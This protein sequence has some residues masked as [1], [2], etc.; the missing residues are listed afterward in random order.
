MAPRWLRTGAE[1]YRRMIEALGAA[2]QSVRFETYLFRS[3]DVGNRFRVALEEAARR[4]VR[5]QVLLDGF[6]SG[7]IPADYWHGLKQAGGEVRIFNPLQWSSF[8]FRDHRKLMLVDDA[9]A[10]VGGFNIAAEYDGDG[11]ERGWRDLGMELSLPKAVHAL[12]KSFDEMFEAFDLRHRLLRRIRHP[13]RR[14]IP[15]GG[16]G[17]VLLSGPRLAGN[18]FRKNLLQSL[19]RA[20]NVRIISGYFLPDFRLRRLLRQVV[21]RGGR[22]ELMLAGKSDVPLTQMAARALYGSLFRGGV[23]IWEYQPQV[24]HAKLAIVDETVFVGSSN[25]DTRSFGINYEVMVR[26][27]EPQITAE[28]REIFSLDQCHAIEITP[29]AWR[30]SQTWFTRCRGF[31]ARVL[32]TKI[33]P[34][35]ARRQ[36]RGLS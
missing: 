25:L 16:Q 7:G 30:A 5:V 22:V 36:R 33:D 10:F 2:R 14:A 15:A 12:A 1:G 32:I 13:L 28:A 18:Q 31:L 9:R 34:W 21:R 6:G 20:K 11:V 35:L 4:G 23:K 8:A 27:D 29:E 24:L 26:L 3:D 19:H 17:P